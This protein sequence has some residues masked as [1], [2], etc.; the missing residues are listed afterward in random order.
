MRVIRFRAEHRSL[1]TPRGGDRGGPAHRD[2]YDI[3]EIHDG[4]L[5]PTLE[6]RNLV[7]IRRFVS[8][9]P[10]WCWVRDRTTTIPTIAIRAC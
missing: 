1:A 6:N 5:M 2:H 9:M 7:I 3:L 4:E 10:N 8:G